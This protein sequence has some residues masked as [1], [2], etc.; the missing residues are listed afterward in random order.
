MR[1]RPN[2]LLGPGHPA[3]QAH[4][5]TRHGTTTLFDAL[6]VL[7]DAVLGGYM[8]CRRNM[9]FTRFL[10]AVETAVPAGKRV[11]VILYNY[12]LHKH[13]K[14]GACLAHDQRWN[15]NARRP[16]ACCRF[17]GH[18]PKLTGLGFRTRQG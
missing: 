2:R 7:D 11:Y 15:F 13:L 4:D 17:G 16:L 6:N 10:D 8:Q 3:G 14:L 5:Y 1:N 12:G 18:C 9:E